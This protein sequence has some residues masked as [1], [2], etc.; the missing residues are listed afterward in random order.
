M[1]LEFSNVKE[2]KTT[3]VW[4]SLNLCPS[5]SK[6]WVHVTVYATVYIQVCVYTGT[7]TQRQVKETN[8][9]VGKT[10]SN[11]QTFHEMLVQKYCYQ[12]HY[13]FSTFQ[14]DRN[15]VSISIA[16]LT[17][18]VFFP[19]LTEMWRPS[20]IFP[21]QIKWWADGM[22]WHRTRVTTKTGTGWPGIWP[23]HRAMTEANTGF[24]ELHFIL[25]IKTEHYISFPGQFWSTKEVGI[26]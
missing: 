17:V 6:A 5:G 26:S 14:M 4:V 7:H 8:G 2:P 15:A 22:T 10:E 25:P 21:T 24:T 18:G 9:K 16:L 13:I 23:H 1:T 11:I 19:I 3:L 20:C 12:N